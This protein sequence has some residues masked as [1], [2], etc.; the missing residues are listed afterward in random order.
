MIVDF[1]DQLADDGRRAS[2]AFNLFP[3]PPITFLLRYALWRAMH[4]Q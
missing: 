3:A 4:L 1:L 2:G